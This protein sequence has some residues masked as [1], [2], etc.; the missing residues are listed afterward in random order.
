M[1]EDVTLEGLL[2]DLADRPASMLASHEAR[3]CQV[4]QGW[5]R[6]MARS[7][8]HDAIG[9]SWVTARW[10]WGPG[11]WPLA[12]CEAVR[13][14]ELDCG[15][16]AHLAEVALQEAGQTV[17]R[18]QLVELHT[19]EQCEQW[20]V[21]WQSVPEAPQWIWGNLV[22]HEAVGVLAGAEL[23]LWDPTDGRWRGP[24]GEAGKLRAI[25]LVRT[26]EGPEPPDSLNWTGRTLPIGR[27]TPL[28]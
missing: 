19:A 27:W 10:C 28:V 17:I 23:R 25:R 18:V 26:S 3:C 9:P 16:L 2:T 12:W 7:L 11:R 20:A 14:T 4:A 5:I 8:T 21:R 13:R 6:A 22:Y 1:T 15:A 24:A